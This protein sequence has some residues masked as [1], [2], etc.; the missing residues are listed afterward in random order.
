LDKES[1]GQAGRQPTH[2]FT[3]NLAISVRYFIER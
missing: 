2:G 3:H 1:T